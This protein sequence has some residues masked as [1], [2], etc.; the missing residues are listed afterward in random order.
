MTVLVRAGAVP[1]TRA[2]VLPPTWGALTPTASG[3]TPS[4]AM[5]AMAIRDAARPK[6]RWGHRVAFYALD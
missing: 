6:V 2:R 4:G 3:R 1:A 5:R